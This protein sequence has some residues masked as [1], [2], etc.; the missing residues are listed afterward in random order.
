MYWSCRHGPAHANFL[1]V[2]TKC[3]K[4]G[5]NRLDGPVSGVILF[6][7]TFPEARKLHMAIMT[8]QVGKFYIARVR[9][10]FP[11][12]GRPHSMLRTVGAHSF[13]SPLQ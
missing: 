11:M 5:V 9:G 6:P 4:P 1:L 3:A 7:R 8:G 2:A 13:G 10:K 12:Y